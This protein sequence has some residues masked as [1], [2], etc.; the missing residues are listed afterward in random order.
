MISSGPER[1]GVSYNMAQ[2]Y[3]LWEAVVQ[4]GRG[5]Y[6]IWHKNTDYEK[7][8]S[9]KVGGHLQ[10]GTR[11]RIMISSGPEREGVIYNMAQEYGLW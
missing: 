2:E 6:T 1:E 5:S 9:R 3:G 8:W 11:M 4:K 10:Y 7:Q